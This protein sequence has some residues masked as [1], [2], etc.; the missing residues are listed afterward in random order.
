MQTKKKNKKNN[1][2]AEVNMQATENT[3][4]WLH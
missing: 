2:K 4:N 3:L 1:Y